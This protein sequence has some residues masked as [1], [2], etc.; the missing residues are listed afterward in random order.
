MSYLCHRLTVEARKAGYPQTKALYGTDNSMER[1]CRFER[2]IQQTRAPSN[3]GINDYVRPFS[4]SCKRGPKLDFSRRKQLTCY[5]MQSETRCHY[6]KVAGSK[7][8]LRRQGRGSGKA[9]STN[10][11][12]FNQRSSKT[13][14]HTEKTVL[15]GNTSCRSCEGNKSGSAYSGTEGG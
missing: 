7:D 13:N 14:R 11:T 5:S 2:S 8:P 3:I 12:E 6:G 15:C 4:I 9:I 1:T 10:E